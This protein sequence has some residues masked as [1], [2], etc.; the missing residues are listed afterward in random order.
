MYLENPDTQCMEFDLS[1]DVKVG[2]VLSWRAFGVASEACCF[3]A[4]SF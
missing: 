2:G 3:N 4:R 1:Y